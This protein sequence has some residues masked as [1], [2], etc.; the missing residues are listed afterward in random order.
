MRPAIYLN[1]GFTPISHANAPGTAIGSDPPRG[2]SKNFAMFCNAIP[3]FCN[4]VVVLGNEKLARK[5]NFGPEE[6]V[7]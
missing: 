1:K 2:R 6:A 7:A 4:M 5:R 3:S